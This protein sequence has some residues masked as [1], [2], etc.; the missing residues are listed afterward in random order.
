L[1]E[2]RIGTV[3]IN[4]NNLVSSLL[5]L[6]EIR[7]SYIDE[8]LSPRGLSTDELLLKWNSIQSVISAGGPYIPDIN[9]PSFSK[10]LDGNI[11]KNP[12]E[13]TILASRLNQN[14]IN[15]QKTNDILESF[16]VTIPAS[17]YYVSS[18]FERR[19]DPIKKSPS[20]HP[21]IDMFGSPSE[22][23]ISEAGGKVL[24]AGVLGPYGNMVEI[25][26]GNGFRSRYGHMRKLL[27]Y[28]GQILGRGQ[29]IGEMGCS[30][31]CTGTH[32]DF[33]V[34]FNDQLQDPLP[35]IKASH[36]ILEI[37]REWRPGL[38]SSNNY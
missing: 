5:N 17:E 6:P 36:E 31:H 22:V 18:K 3:T 16:P 24:K 9:S 8:K 35:Y 25:D 15:L 7:L 19:A 11:G 33:E 29:K 28:K 20:V 13:F 12:E 4:Q 21:G 37:E 30:G 23:I 26:H 32:L 14:W 1:L 10:I 34:W 38:H 2:G 27:V